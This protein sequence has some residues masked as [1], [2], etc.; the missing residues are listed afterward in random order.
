MTA[1]GGTTIEDRVKTACQAAGVE[2]ARG[3]KT[4]TWPEGLM[5]ESRDVPEKT[6]KDTTPRIKK[7][8]REARG[9]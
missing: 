5:R 2:N 9:V 6:L 1:E 3:R 4:E 7:R 8:R